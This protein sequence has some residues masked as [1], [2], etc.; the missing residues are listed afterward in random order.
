MTPLAFIDRIRR[1]L[2]G[3]LH[4]TPSPKQILE[5]GIDEYSNATMKANN[6]GNAWAVK[7]LTVTA[8]ADT[9]R[10]EITAADFAKALLV[11]TVPQNELQEPE[12]ILEFTQIEQI[13]REWAWLSDSPSFSLWL[14][15]VSQNARYAAVFREST[16]TGF[17]N[18]L[19]LR[20]TP[21]AGEEYRVLY[22]VGNWSG[23]ITSDNLI[24]FKLP[25]PELDFYFI[26]LVADGLLAYCKW[27]NDPVENAMKAKTL[28]QS[29]EK[30]LARYDQ[31]FRDFIASLSVS[32]IVYAD[33]FG[34][35]NIY[36]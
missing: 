16:S 29:F 26:T 31:T 18:Y 7:E 8:L 12:M 33:S 3:P 34:E 14:W 23:G 32:D 2:D 15:N 20:P 21:E 24:D 11:A 17:R 4:Q 13:P 35:T 30:A 5:L 28:S 1:R 19:E 36:Y 27:S 22:Q 25:F 9:R 10:Y 6:S